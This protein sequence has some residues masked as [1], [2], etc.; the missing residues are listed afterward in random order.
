[1][2]ERSE[3]LLASDFL[4][5]LE[6][7]EL[8]SKRIFRGKIRGERR[9]ARKGQSVEFADHRGYV[10]GDDL[11]FLDWNLYARL[12]R[13][14]VKLFLEEEDLHLYVLLDTSASMAFGEPSKF[15]CAQRIAAALGFVGLIHSDRVVIETLAADERSPGLVLRGRASVW[16]LL[17]HL[18]N[19]P[20]GGPTD[21]AGGVRNF[22]IRRQGKGILILLSDLLDKQGYEP[23]LRRL[24][25]RGMDVYVIQ[26]LSPEELEPDYAGELALTDCEDGEL[27]EIT[28]TVP[29]LDAYRRTVQNYLAEVRAYCTRRGISYLAAD[30]RLPFEDVVT[31]YLRTRGLLR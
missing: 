1:M 29:L 11:R 26:I 14:F 22:C 13:L 28:A 4:A 20:V 17:E 15:R 5:R 12:D 23:A 8:V 3:P 10:S 24:V 7:L 9:S 16:R 6:N 21:L 30:S 31:K 25:N 18:E 2:A 19:L 27:A